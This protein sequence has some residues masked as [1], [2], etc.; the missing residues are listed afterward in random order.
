MAW[1]LRIGGT[2][3]HLGHYLIVPWYHVRAVTIIQH[4][5]FP[6][7]FIVTLR[8]LV[9]IHQSLYPH[10]PP[11]GIYF[12]ALVEEAF[13]RIKKPFAVIESGGRNQPRHDLMV[14]DR[15]ISLKT[16]TGLSTGLRQITITKLCTTER[17]PWEAGVLIKRVMDH[18]SRYD[19]ILMFRA[20]WEKE[21]VRYQLVDIPVE[22]LR[23]IDEIL[24]QKV[25]RR[26]G[27][28]S[29]ATDVIRHGERIF[30]VHFDASDGKCSIR[31]L[32]IQHCIMLEEWSVRL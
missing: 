24:L 29:L 7:D 4:E 26:T 16:E 31:N 32:G 30:R 2:N 8:G 22:T 18:L 14:D 1:R 9:G 28:Q 13:R 17:E 20:V 10:T 11:Q 5:V 19:I 3:T 25:G 21:A 23:R 12:E 15:R 27:R 6:P